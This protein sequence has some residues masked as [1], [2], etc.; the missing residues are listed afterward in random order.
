[1]GRSVLSEVPRQRD[2]MAEIAGPSRSLQNDTD[3]WQ[4]QQTVA[5][6]TLDKWLVRV[7]SSDPALFRPDPLMLRGCPSHRDIR[8]SCAIINHTQKPR[9]TTTN[10]KHPH[11]QLLKNP[12]K[13]IFHILL[14]RARSQA[15][16]VGA[17]ACLDHL[18][19]PLANGTF[20]SKVIFPLP[21]HDHQLM[22]AHPS[23]HSLPHHLTRIPSQELARTHTV[24]ARKPRPALKSGDA[25]ALTVMVGPCASGGANPRSDQPLGN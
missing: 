9:Q 23:T 24:R 19:T 1:M 22:T 13:R 4:K 2:P 3:G 11:T 25:T 8:I 6:L 12:A 21:T 15:G 14:A 7:T 10:K 5:S 20:V 18:L 17:S 16:S